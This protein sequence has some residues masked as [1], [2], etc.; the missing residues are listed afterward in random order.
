LRGRF[1]LRYGKKQTERRALARVRDSNK[2]SLELEL[3]SDEPIYSDFEQ[4]KLAS[5]LTLLARNVVS[6]IRW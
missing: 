5:Y 6:T 2:A 3:F 1:T 4:L